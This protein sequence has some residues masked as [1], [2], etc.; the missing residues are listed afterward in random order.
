MAMVGLCALLLAWTG[1]VVGLPPAEVGFEFIHEAAIPVSGG[2]AL[3]IIICLYLVAI[4]CFG[5]WC[6]VQPAGLLA[7]YSL[8]L[9]FGRLFASLIGS[10]RRLSNCAEP[11]CLAVIDGSASVSSSHRIAAPNPAALAGAA[12]LLE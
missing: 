6:L 10:L 7:G 3:P 9:S 11:L 5:G 12:P 1:W 2:V 8:L 4:A